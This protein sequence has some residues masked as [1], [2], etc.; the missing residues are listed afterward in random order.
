MNTLTE[1]FWK[2]VDKIGPIHPYKPHLG[3]CWPWTASVD[4]NGYGQIGEGGT[5]G[6]MLKAHRVSWE[7]HNGPIPIGEGYHGICVRHSCDNPGCVNPAHLDEG[8]HQDNMTDMKKRGRA[9]SGALSGELCGA[10]KLTEDKVSEIR[11][12]YIEGSRTFGQRAL[13]RKHN[14]SHVQVGRIVQGKNW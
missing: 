6:K 13:A 2:N 8:S 12:D 14:I 5:N 9:R 7:L 10:S 3:R 11:R 1:R 4:K